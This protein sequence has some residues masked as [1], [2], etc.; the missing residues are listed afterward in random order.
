MGN[1][2]GAKHEHYKK[3]LKELGIFMVLEDRVKRPELRKGDI[4]VTRLHTGPYAPRYVIVAATPV[5][6]TLY[7]AGMWIVLSRYHR[8]DY[9]YLRP[10]TNQELKKVCPHLPTPN[11]LISCSRESG[12]IKSLED[13]TLEE[14]R[15]MRDEFQKGFLACIKI[16]CELVNFIKAFQ[17]KYNLTRSAVLDLKNDEVRL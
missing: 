10:L 17:H 16:S 14:I 5:R 11:Y 13:F 8:G 12:V 2:N 6:K 4:L 9:P 15:T 7:R 3:V 1:I